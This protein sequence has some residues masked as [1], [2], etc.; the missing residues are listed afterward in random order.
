MTSV[1]LFE[2]RDREQ[3]DRYVNSSSSSACYHLSGWKDLI[4]RSFGHKTFYLMAEDSQDEIRGVLPL[5]HL[6]SLLFGSFMVSLPY[7]NYGGICGDDFET[8]DVLLNEAIN[9][10]EKEN[11]EHIELRHTNNVFD[12]L[13]VKTVKVSMRLGLPASPEELWSSFSSNLRRKIRK[14]EK[15]GFSWRF[16]REEALDGFYTI[17][18]AN[19]RDLGTPVYSKGFFRNMLQSFPKSTWICTVKTKEDQPIAAGFLVGFKDR[20]EIPWVSSLRS[21]NR[22]YTNQFLY[23]NILK[24][25]CERGYRVFDFGRS[26]VGEGTYKFKEQ[27][28]AEPVQLYWHYCLK[29]GHP[30]P[31][32]NP[33][34]PKYSLAISTWKRLP[35]RLTKLI[36]PSIVKNLP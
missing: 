35:V 18:S 20:L 1:R 24:F 28:G 31:E 11:V 5:V 33:K 19:M 32:L 13:P 34:N 22:L 29:S 9:I 12:K 27:W 17:F 2:D 3:W 8:Q 16:G 4:E 30:L 15:E 10:A 21:Y 6:K 26:T 23:W 25:A 36:G 7:F 14:P